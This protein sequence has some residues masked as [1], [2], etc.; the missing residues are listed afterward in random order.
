MEK[1][2][3]YEDELKRVDGKKIYFYQKAYHEEVKSVRKHV[4]KKDVDL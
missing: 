1:F 4:L 3:Y 2:F